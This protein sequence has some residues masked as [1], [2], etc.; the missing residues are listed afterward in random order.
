MQAKRSFRLNLSV[1][2]GSMMN[3]VCEIENLNIHQLG[4]LVSK[5]ENYR[6]TCIAQCTELSQFRNHGFEFP[7][8]FILT[9]A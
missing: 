1:S 9:K 7:E 6:T 3:E 5:K 2:I 4:G 8:L